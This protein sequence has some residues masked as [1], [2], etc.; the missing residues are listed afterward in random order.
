MEGRD[1]E[2]QFKMVEKRL[3]TMIE[4]EEMRLRTAVRITV[5]QR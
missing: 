1:R 5:A 2:R 3:A 4:N